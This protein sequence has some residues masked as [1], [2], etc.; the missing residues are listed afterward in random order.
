MGVSPAAGDPLHQLR[1]QDW[2]FPF[3]DTNKDNDIV[4][5]PCH[6]PCGAQDP[7]AEPS[8]EEPRALSLWSQHQL[9]P[10]DKDEIGTR[11][12]EPTSRPTTKE[13]DDV[14]GS[15]AYAMNSVVSAL[16]LWR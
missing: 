12:M 2:S 9:T 7:Q 8:T 6:I 16:S 14:E 3:S 1:D 15:C 4:P 10:E 13:Y 11:A 5:V